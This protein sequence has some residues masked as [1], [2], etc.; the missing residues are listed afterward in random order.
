MARFEKDRLFAA[1]QDRRVARL[2]TEH[3]GVG[4]DVGTA[5]KND[6]DDADGSALFHDLE[7]VR[8]RPL[9]DDLPGGIVEQGHVSNALGHGGDAVM[10]EAEPVLHRGGEPELIGGGE[11][12]SVGGENVR[13]RAPSRRRPSREGS[14]FSSR[15]EFCQGVG[16]G[17][18]LFA[19]L[20]RTSPRRFL[21]RS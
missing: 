9:A 8:A 3:G 18:G 12:F 15:G 13:P 2:E 20:P 7:A 4:G 11:I 17:A 5:F 21:Q 16:G 6:P 14:H 10:I 19:H 1:S